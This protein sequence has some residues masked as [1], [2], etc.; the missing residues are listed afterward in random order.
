MMPWNRLRRRRSPEV[1][2]DVELRDHMKRQL[3]DY[4]ES[5]LSADEAHR[6]V[7]LDFG[8]VALAKDECRD[9]RPLQ[10]LEECVRDARLGFRSLLRERLFAVSVTLIL[11]VGVGT[12]VAMFS[13]L[14][15]VVLRPLPY[16]KAGELATLATHRIARN[17]FDGTSVPNMLD[18]RQQSAS[19]TAMTLYRRTSSSYVLFRGADE[20][21]RAREGLVDAE[22]FDVLG[23]P[24]LLGRI[25]SRDDFARQERVV[26]LSE[27]LWSDQ[28]GRS[29]D[30]LGRRL[31]IDGTDHVVIG[32][33]PRAFQLPT[34]DTR[35]WRPLTV[36]GSWWQQVQHARD[37]DG[38]EVIGRLAPGVDI[39][40]AR[41]EMATIAAR[42]RDGHESNR[43]L[44]IRVTPLAHHVI[45]APIIRGMWLAFGAVLSLL[46][47]V[48]ANVGGLLTAR[49]T[50]RRRELAVR[51]ALGAGRLRL[52]RQLLAECVSLWIVAAGFG[53]LLAAG[54]LPVVVA[55]GPTGLPRMDEVGLDAMAVALA[56]VA[57]LVVVTLC[58]TAPALVASRPD[59]TVAFG[60]RDSSGPTRH[61][62][63]DVLV[64]TQTAG[65]VALL[66]TAVLF[67][68]SFLRAQA[69][70]PGY[71][72]QQLI[73]AR[74]ERPAVPGFFLE[75][76]ERI[77][78]LPGVV[79]VGGVT[80]FFIRRSGDQQVTIEGREFADA[81]GRMP[82]LVLD[83]ATPGYFRSTGIA[84]LEGRDFDDRDVLSGAQPV[85]IVSEAMA[86]RFW[87]GE[88][89]VGQRLVSGGTPP[90]DNRWAT[91]IGVVSDMRRE[92]LD[93]AP[94]LSVFVPRLLQTMDLTIR[95]EARAD[96][97]IPA[98]RQEIRSMDPSL[99]VSSITTAEGR[100]AEQLGSR[101]FETQVLVAFAAIALLLAA[102]GVYALVALQV[103]LRTREIGIRSALG[104]ERRA[105]VTMFVGRGVRLVGLGA[106]LGIVT[107][108][109]IGK[110]LQTQLYETAAVSAPV[111]AGA[112]AAMILIAACAAWWPARQTAR[113]SPMTV[114]RDG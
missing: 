93:A 104:A 34:T 29:A 65:A 27:G 14:N 92:R 97:L 17:Q 60:A 33:M 90:R 51:A 2:L 13:V 95:T 102:A 112:A 66:V 39:E 84:V 114:L 59:A 69:E 110:V 64:T 48:C 81:A 24:P 106:T 75:A 76:R 87:P 54:L 23:T 61:R 109:S 86:R 7:R 25:F 71:P 96:A 82:R 101:R 111:Y 73:V 83:S 3:D 12:T 80:D 62:L 16:A 99:A 103:T 89:A 105:I 5:G 35:F 42:L 32:V 1:D 37:G 52:V 31:S 94:I 45:G 49:A 8:D 70:D 88:S 20:P 91:V 85:V 28:F 40:E 19:F 67:G 4:L 100:L 22:F 46:A 77:E 9:V 26:V 47:I 30:V 38:Y 78:R 43:D 41:I 21:Q 18:W 74:I 6:R 107:A 68:Q 63:Q 36:L 56:I 50:R 44:D 108:I 113:V 57:G 55:S 58:G 98:I 11:A 15:G 10:W 79:A 53:V 72:A